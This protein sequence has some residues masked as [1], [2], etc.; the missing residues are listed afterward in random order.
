MRSSIRQA[1]GMKNAGLWKVNL[2]ITTRMS[3]TSGR[4]WES[5]VL[6]A[7]IAIIASCPGPMRGIRDAQ[8]GKSRDGDRFGEDSVPNDCC[9]SA[10]LST[11]DSVNVSSGP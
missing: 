6:V 2:R 8:G 7:I 10:V 11:P 5:P 3:P 9:Q 1:N 4:V